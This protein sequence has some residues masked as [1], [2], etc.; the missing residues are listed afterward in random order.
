MIVKYRSEI[1]SLGKVCNAD[2]I[3]THKQVITTQDFQD[4]LNRREQDQ[5]DQQY[6]ILDMRNNYEY[7]L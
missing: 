1:V 7:L 5:L 6:V 4:I 2:E 3:K